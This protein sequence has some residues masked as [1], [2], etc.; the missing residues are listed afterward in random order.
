VPIAVPIL[1]VAAV[2]MLP[3]TGNYPRIQRE[4]LNNQDAVCSGTVFTIFKPQ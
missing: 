3:I 2:G 1:T 4:Y